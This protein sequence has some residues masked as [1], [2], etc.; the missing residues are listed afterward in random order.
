MGV[1]AL[2]VHGEVDNSYFLPDL[3]VIFWLCVGVVALWLREA[4]A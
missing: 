3:S 1:L 2:V 4:P